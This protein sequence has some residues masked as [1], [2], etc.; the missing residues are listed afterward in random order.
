MGRQQHL[1]RLALGRSPYQDTPVHDA[2]SSQAPPVLDGNAESDQHAQQYDAKGRPIN[3]AIEM[4]SARMRDAQ[5]SVLALVGV[6][7]DR[8][9]KQQKMARRAKYIKQER[10]KVLTAENDFGEELDLAASV[11]RSLAL[12]FAESLLMRLQI[13]LID[14]K[15]SFL[16][17]ISTELEAVRHDGW[18]GAVNVLLPGIPSY[19]LHQM[20]RS[21]LGVGAELIIDFVQ[22]F[23]IRQRGLRYKTS[24]MIRRTCDVVL[25]AIMAIVDVV[26]L[27]LEYHSTI[28]MLGLAPTLP[29]LPS[30]R[31]FLPRNLGSLHPNGSDSFISSKFIRYVAVPGG[32][33]L[34]RSMLHR[35]IADETSFIAWLTSFRYP[36]I[37]DYSRHQDSRTQH[38]LHFIQD[39]IGY[40]LQH[41]LHVRLFFTSW[42]GWNVT[43]A[44]NSRHSNEMALEGDVTLEGQ[45]DHSILKHRHRAT[46]LAHLVPTSLAVSVDQL[47]QTVL[48][49]P[50]D[51]VTFRVVAASF[52]ASPFRKSLRA[53]RY[54][55][56]LCRPFDALMYSSSGR[57]S[58]NGSSFGNYSSKIGLGLALLASIHA[59][60]FAG[61]YRASRHFGM[62]S[63]D[64][65]CRWK[66]GAL[67][68]VHVVSLSFSLTYNAIRCMQPPIRTKDDRGYQT[69]LSTHYLD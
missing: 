61:V 2:C 37:N 1:T 55:Q 12:W 48:F 16:D 9:S 44:E 53:M 10:Q 17:A 28:Q 65:D 35:D 7:E 41:A 32:L 18:T 8:T 31:S 25:L 38:R 20:L 30:L 45:P 24:R 42:C 58:F 14:A 46:S 60:L 4:E 62:R 66:I 64:W 56:H 13:G 68:G 43:N 59:V 15:L 29:W 33:I 50:F 22:K 27:P 40:T 57:I 6:V 23:V 47:I 67:V 21:G 69:T 52:M 36:A 39:P 63:F 3:P 34:L 26:L 5:N 51:I 49:L 19:L 54:E 11:A